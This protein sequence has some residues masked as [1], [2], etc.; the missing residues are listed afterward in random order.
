MPSKDYQSK[1]DEILSRMAFKCAGGITQDGKKEYS[2]AEQAID[3]L[4]SSEC[5][6]E[7]E[8]LLDELEKDL[9]LDVESFGD[10]PNERVKTVIASKRQQHK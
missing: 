3:Q 2:E 10:I 4:I 5:Q 6:G 8:K 7:R 1:L 9:G